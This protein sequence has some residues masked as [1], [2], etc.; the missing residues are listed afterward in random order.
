MARGEGRG[1]ARR[2]V[3]PGDA[4]TVAGVLATMGPV[5]RGAADEGRAFL[6]G[7]RARAEDAIAAGDTL[8]VWA[9]RG[10]PT[11]TV[12]DVTRILTRS[13]GLVA[14]F[15]PAGLP[16]EPDRRGTSSLV[17]EL[18]SLLGSVP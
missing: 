2:V 15:K 3:R 7:R 4:P 6:N 17:T 13:G 11:S 1:A 8:E 12:R 18:A 10:A 9:A 5:A 16:T 14:A